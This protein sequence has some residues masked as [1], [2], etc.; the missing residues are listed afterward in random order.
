[1]VIGTDSSVVALT[2]VDG[3]RV[4]LACGVVMNDEASTFGTHFDGGMPVP[5]LLAAFAD[6]LEAK[7]LDGW[8]GD[9]AVRTEPLHEAYVG[10]DDA[11]DVVR[12]KLGIFLDMADGNLVALW[13]HGGAAPAVV[14]LESEGQYS[15]LAPSLEAFLLRWSAGDDLSEGQLLPGGEEVRAPM[16]RWLAAR[17]VRP[18]AQAPVPDFRAW[19][20]EV[21]A[22]AAAARAQR[23]AREPF[24]APGPAR[25][26]AAVQSLVDRC[27]PLLGGRSDE[28][29]LAALLADLGI[30]VRTL[31]SAW[32]WRT[33][34]LPDVG[35]ELH[36]EWPWG[37]GADREYDAAEREQLRRKRVRA[38]G[39]MTVYAA[40]VQGVPS[41]T[42][43]GFPGRLPYGL[44]LGA[45]GA[46][47]AAALDAVPNGVRATV[48]RDLYRTGE[49]RL[50][51]HLEH[52]YDPAVDRTISV[53]VEAN[54]RLVQAVQWH[55][56]RVDHL[57]R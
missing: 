14:Y 50:G 43:A 12:P 2:S 48:N 20:N 28:P 3:C 55:A 24:D 35:V 21:T 38:L 36:F 22:A 51:L 37:I 31:R 15:V 29:A 10:D 53:D 17:G 23:I 25:R 57:F 5:P 32:D 44:A 54:S 9:C 42:F 18:R 49:P 8:L 45:D 1:V 27:G 13:D 52:C 6:W 39:T 34:Q 41:V 26:A 7:E 11:F 33:I 4:L 40:G 16:G 47:A 19:L 56:G 46:A 30:D